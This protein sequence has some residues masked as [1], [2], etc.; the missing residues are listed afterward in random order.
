[1]EITQL[2]DKLHQ[3]IP[4]FSELMKALRASEVTAWLVGGC[5]RDLLLGRQCSDIDVVSVEDPSDWARSWAKGRGHWFWL[6]QQRRQSRILLP[7]GI[8]FDFA[9][10]R[11]SVIEADL[12][13]RDFTINAMA[14][15]TGEPGKLLD[16]LNGIT[17]LHNCCLK[18]CSDDTFSDDPLRILKGARHA[19]VLNFTF[20]KNSLNAMADHAS[21]ITVVAAERVRDELFLMLNVRD[22][23]NALQPL[24]QTGVLSALFGSPAQEWVPQRHR[25]YHQY[26]YDRSEDLCQRHQTP[27]TAALLK[28]QK[29]FLLAVLLWAYAPARYQSNYRKLRLSREQQRVLRALRCEIAEEWFAKT[30]QLTTERLL[31]L[32]VEQ[33]N[34]CGLQRLFYWGWCAGRISEEQIIALLEAYWSL[35]KE[36][37][38]PHLLDGH[39]M[40][41]FVDKHKIATYQHQIKLEELEGK[42]DGPKGA[43]NWMKTHLP[44]DKI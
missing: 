3:Q 24:F 41:Q 30:D 21:L 7:Q 13:A 27:V 26:I 28:H 32:A 16:P 10:L 37:R 4:V 43:L 23:Y 42:I 18:V 6:D 25:K 8:S 44:I 39:V 38:I 11:A 33:L 12:S 36:G 29:L 19:A 17:D 20:E 40:A 22:S 2:I 31:A 15:P 14:V 34:P 35:E 9:P 5:V 1:M